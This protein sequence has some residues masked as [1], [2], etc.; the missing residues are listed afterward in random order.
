[1]T[2]LEVRRVFR[3]SARGWTCAMAALALLGAP[4]LATA[5]QAPPGMTGSIG[6][7]PGMP[8]PAL[9]AQLEG[10]TFEQRLDAQLPLDATFRD[11]T[12]RTVR[13]GEYFGR[14]PVLLAF[15]YYNCPMLCMQV[16]NGISTTLSVTPFVPGEDFE[17]VLVSFDPRDTPADAAVKKQEHLEHWE[18]EG[19][20]AGWHFLTGDEDQIRRVTDAAGFTYS[21][22]ERI[23]Q[24]AH[25][26][27]V[28]V[29]TPQGRLSRYFYGIEYSAKEMRM[30]LVESGEGKIGSLVDDI[31]LYCY[32]YD[33]A[34]GRYG[35]VVM[36]M[37]RLGG[38]LTIALVAGFIVLM[39]RR[40]LR[41]PVEG[42]A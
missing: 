39:R 41:A 14:K 6:I 16:M 21:W 28:L 17:V 12:G 22:D 13:L 34:S 15:V 1:M 32:H 19:T 37:V 23:E 33:P 36:N 8:S 4:A 18:A 7:A 25:V 26:S 24:Y 40:E 20:A 10:V 29:V 5:Q 42:R 35:V 38:L 11:E 9:P 2:S 27:G 30:A 3:A 31:L